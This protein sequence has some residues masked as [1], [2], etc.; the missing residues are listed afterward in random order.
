MY[1]SR[2]MD[3]F[4]IFFIA[5]HLP[6]QPKTFH[7]YHNSSGFFAILQIRYCVVYPILFPQSK[8]IVIGYL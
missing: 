5:L 2:V 4:Y 3:W 7:I 8:N 1:G 6:K